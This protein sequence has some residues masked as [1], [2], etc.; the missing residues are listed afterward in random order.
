MMTSLTEVE[1]SWILTYISSHKEGLYLRT[2]YSGL[3][4]D[5]DIANFDAE[6]IDAEEFAVMK[7][8]YEKL[9]VD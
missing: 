7:S 5:W 2:D 4:D 3:M 6:G 9:H 1:I 8:I